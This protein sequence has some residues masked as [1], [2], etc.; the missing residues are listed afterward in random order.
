MSPSDK[1]LKKLHWGHRG[2]A[3]ASGLLRV[4]NFRP[5][6]QG[7]AEFGDGFD[8]NLTVNNNFSLIILTVVVRPSV[9]SEFN[10]FSGYPCAVVFARTYCRSFGFHPVR[11]PGV[12]DPRTVRVDATV[13]GGPTQKQIRIISII[14]ATTNTTI[15]GDCTL[16]FP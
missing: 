13:L 11:P 12:P 16:L 4:A 5:R 6:F 8:Y 3:T 15:E 9:F 7:R 1:S 10:R 2:D 14:S